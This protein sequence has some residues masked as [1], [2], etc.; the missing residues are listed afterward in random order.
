[1]DGVDGVD[2]VD[3]GYFHPLLRGSQHD[4]SFENNSWGT[5]RSGVL[6]D[7]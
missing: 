2:K 5:R 3:S 6:P 1:M 4:A 7:K